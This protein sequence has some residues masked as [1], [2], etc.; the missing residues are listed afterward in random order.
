MPRT[1]Q[2]L[3]ALEQMLERTGN[4]PKRLDVVRRAQRFK[5][6]WVELAEALHGLRKTHAYQAWGYSDLQDYCQKELA[7]RPATV[8]KLLLSFST[9]ERHA[10]DVLQR[11]GVARNIPSVEAIDYF[12]RALGDEDRPGPVRRLD[13]ADDMIEQLRSA[14][15]DEGQNVREL[16]ERFNPVINPKP[17]HDQNAEVARKARAA[18]QRLH[19]L[20]P[21]VPGL[22]EARV[23][24]VLAI[25]EALVSDL[26]AMLDKNA[27]K[28]AGKS[29][30]RERAHAES[31]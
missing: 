21:E 5:R 28:T 20:V 3:D 1:N 26:D 23:G 6:S 7:L 13:A 30:K 16:R 14:V 10:P 15:F 24:R 12:T 17:E 18:A 22:T 4:D 31:D 9:L 11:D 8:D 25:L 29:S 2:K 19:E 27:A